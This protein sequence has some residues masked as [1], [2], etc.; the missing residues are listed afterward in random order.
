[1]SG[2]A[3]HTEL[4][5]QKVPADSRTTDQMARVYFDYALSGIIE[6]DRHGTIL[7]ANPASASILGRDAK[8]LEGTNLLD[9]FTPS[10]LERLQRHWQL[11]Q[12]QGISQVEPSLT[13]PNGQQLIISMASIQIDDNGYMHVFDDVTAL[14]RAEE[15]I[16]KARLAAE[17]ANRAKSEFLA[18]ISHEIR[19]PLNGI[20]GLSE[21]A[22][23][24]KLPPDARDYLDGI[25]RSGR[26]LLTLVS[27]ILDAA[28]MESGQFSINLRPFRVE[29]LL[30]DLEDLRKS[31]VREKGLAME[32]SIAHDVPPWVEGDR[33]RVAQCLRQL[34]SNAIKFTSTGH[35]A[36]TVGCVQRDNRE[37]LRLEVT[38]TGVGIEPEDMAR[39]FVPFS[40]GD[41]STSRRFGGSGLGLYLAQALAR[42]MGGDLLA[43]STPGYGSRFTLELPLLPAAQP[44]DLRIPAGD[45]PQEFRGQRVLL[46]ED[47]AINRLVASRVLEMAGIVVSIAQNGHEAITQACVEPLPALILMDVQ[48]PGMDGLAATR[49][50]RSRGCTLPIIGLSAGTGLIEQRACE[51]AG[52][53]DFLPKPLDFDELWGCLTRWLPPS[54]AT[55]RDSDQQGQTD[56]TTVAHLR[57]VF[58]SSHGQAGGRLAEHIRQGNRREAALIVHTL[59]SAAALVGLEQTADM[60]RRLESMLESAEDDELVVM[61]EAI[62]HDLDRFAGPPI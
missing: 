58:L 28:T 60:A 9:A 52:M 13:L 49:E 18:N 31:G 44:Q 56:Q 15:E 5:R 30:A 62:Q 2:S 22:L 41:T 47:D 1:M 27:D 21:L 40:Q 57:Q 33:L 11:M 12:E 35:V 29:D 25:I 61:C 51:N 7:K 14:R 16:Q 38:D 19:T 59:K 34:V 36:L 8:H 26:R 4:A 23:H 50:L 37:W 10:F 55:T 45:V 20:L 46:V 17:R 32:F 24:T 48:M 43:E 54:S 53:S 6:T 42:Q 39:L 3:V